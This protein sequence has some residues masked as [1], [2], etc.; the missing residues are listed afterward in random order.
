[1][2][3]DHPIP[4]A[5]GPHTAPWGH[6]VLSAAVLPLMLA[7]SSPGRAAGEEP[8]LLLRQPT[9]SDDHVAFVYAGDLWVADRDGTSPRRL[10]VHPGLERDPQLSPDGRWVAFTG[11]YDGNTDVFVVGVEGGQPRRLTYHPGA[12]QARGWTPDG[13]EVLF[14]SAR[15]NHTTRSGHLFAV[16]RDG[17]Q[18]RRLPMPSVERAAVSP[19][20]RT[21]AYTPYRDAFDSWKRYRGGR[22]TPIW[23]FDLESHA[24]EEVPHADGSDS[25]PAWAGDTLV[26]MSDRD[27]VMNVYATT[28]GSGEV[29]RIT[30]HDDMDVRHVAARGTTIVYEQG[31]RLRELE[32][33][34]V[35]AAPAVGRP[36]PIHV[37]PDLP[38]LRPHLES[39]VSQIRWVDVSPS[40]KRAIVEAR[41]EI[42]TVPAEHGDVRD[43]TGT[44]GVHERFPAWSPD[45]ASVAYLSDASG[46]YQLVIAP[47]DGRGETRTVS[48]GEPSFY[49][50][51]VWSPDGSRIAY[52]DKRLNLW[53]LELDGGAPRLVATDPYDEPPRSMDPRWSPDGRYLA[54]AQRQ[55]N[56]MR[57]I[58]VYDTAT[59]ARHRITD[60]MSDA[61]SP[62]WSRDGR[63]LYFA[64]SVDR[65]LATGWLD[66]SSYERP[67]RRSLYLV[68]LSDEASSPLAPRSDDEPSASEGERRG[69]ARGKGGRRGAGADGEDDEAEPVVVDLDPDGIGGR[70]VPLP[71]EPG[72]VGDLRTAE[73][74]LLLYLAW[75][76][77][78]GDDAPR[79]MRF[80]TEERES[81]ELL[82]DTWRYA[83]SADG[84]ALLHVDTSRTF[85]IVA[86]DAEPAAAAEAEPLDLSGLRATVDPR[87]EFAQMVDEAWRIERDFFYDPGMHGADWDAVLQRYRPWVAH[88]GHRDDVNTIIGQMIGELR[89][90]HAYRWGGDYPDVPHVDVGLLGADLEAHQ[91]AWR[92][93]RILD[94]D[95]WDPD[96]RSPLLEPG[97]GVSVGD[98]LLAV[99]GRPVAPPENLYAAFVGT[100]GRQTV[101]TVNTRP[102]LAGAREVTVVPVADESGLRYRAW[103][104]ANRRLVDEATGGRVAYLHMPNTA[105][106]GYRS[107]N[108]YFYAQLDREAVIIDERFN[109]GGSVADYIIDMLMRRPLNMNV[110]REGRDYP[111]P[112]GVIDGP[113]VMIVNQDA[114]SG[115]DCMPEYFRLMG[116]GKLVGTRTW[117]GLIGIYDYPVLMDGGVVTAPRIAFYGADGRWTAENAG[118]SPDVEVEMTPA[119]VIAGH[120]PQLERAIEVILEELDRWPG[121]TMR[122]PSFPRRED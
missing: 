46:E 23:L 5:S 13:G 114:G 35:G 18:P 17:G 33:P 41:G 34:E 68:V 37:S 93:A 94:A 122:R 36:L 28:P 27:G 51:P 76:D 53:V 21:V 103:V 61:V 64:A 4:V 77:G 106:D 120:D 22:T 67:V 39:L 95:P 111:S 45:G 80:D 43:I 90:G 9:V 1:M 29:R 79:L 56:H 38:D 65:A 50:E 24:V 89:A 71:V 10:T 81:E 11:E 85:R 101:L 116:L 12:D 70:I 69:P 110:T 47:Q 88:A 74:G 78:S 73:G 55:D 63:V 48:L 113:R 100:A 112:L 54:Y 102:T 3:T 14:R 7:A 49:Y 91:G 40:G 121:S 92:I 44:P 72:D 117:G 32:L 109:G 119:L 115:G 31:G 99:D 62:A 26:F 2:S 6:R 105:W 98:Y 83:V 87:A 60:G 59:G 42:L 108:R 96:L 75:P 58:V 25:S 104:E 82:A 118:V 66:M 19:D 97:I 84:T 20:G 107:F 30:D 86:A 15:D 57:A 16:P 52:T 8:T